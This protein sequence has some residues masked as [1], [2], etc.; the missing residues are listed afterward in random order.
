MNYKDMNF[1]VL[2]YIR[3]EKEPG[4]EQTE[5]LLSYL[6]EKFGDKVSLE[7]KEDK[8]LGKGFKIEAGHVRYENGEA[9]WTL[10]TVLDWSV[11]SK[12]EQIKEDISKERVADYLYGM[13]S[14]LQVA[15]NVLTNMS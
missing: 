1:Q 10:E 11:A 8:T 7:W 2:A 6:T 15:E 14:E 5:K 9:K 13:A 4:K 3:S 12:A